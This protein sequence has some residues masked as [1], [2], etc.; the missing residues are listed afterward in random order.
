M[1]QNTKWVR[2]IFFAIICVSIIAITSWIAIPGLSLWMCA[3]AI[4]FRKPLQRWYGFRDKHQELTDS[5]QIA[6]VRSQERVEDIMM[7]GLACMFFAAGALHIL[8]HY[9]II[10]Q[11]PLFSTGM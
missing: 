4:L 10:P 1:F 6:A 2:F 5:Q 11:G 8:L 9:N 3:L 7:I